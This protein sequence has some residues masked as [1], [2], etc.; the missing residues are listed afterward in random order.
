MVHVA[1][2]RVRGVRE[3]NLFIKI[4][5]SS[6][7]VAFYSSPSHSMKLPFTS[8]ATLTRRC[9][10]RLAVTRELQGSSKEEQ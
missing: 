8:E 10:Q 2:A 1:A 7:K 6:F 5:S 9:E 3:S 4:C